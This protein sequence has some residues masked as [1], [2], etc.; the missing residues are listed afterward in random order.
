MLKKAETM[1]KESLKIGGK[2]ISQE[3]L[4]G[5]ID[6]TKPYIFDESNPYRRKSK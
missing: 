1:S 6:D 4:S 5:I 3:H 2:N